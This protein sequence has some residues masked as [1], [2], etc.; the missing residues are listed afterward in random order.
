LVDNHCKLTI[1]TSSIITLIF[2]RSK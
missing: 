2:T 1:I